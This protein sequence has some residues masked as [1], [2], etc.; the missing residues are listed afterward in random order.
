MSNNVRATLVFWTAIGI[1]FLLPAATAI[2]VEARRGM[3]ILA[4]AQQW[5]AELFL[6]GYNEFLLSLIESAPF[7]I[8]AVF[9]LFHLTASPLYGSQV[10]RARL[11]GVF[12]AIL[13]GTAI[14]VW[15][16]I[17]IR[18]SHSSTAAIGYLVLPFYVLFAMPIGYL[19][20]RLIAKASGKP[21]EAPPPF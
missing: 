7:I 13:T 19:A 4:S 14:S 9:S 17:A 20:G 18:T 6:P 5:A 15:I 21:R 3:P 11:A 8:L 1:G 2:G 12:G 10:L 16:L